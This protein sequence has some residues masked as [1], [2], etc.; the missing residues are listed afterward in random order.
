ML[1][2]DGEVLRLATAIMST[3]LIPRK[4]ETD[5]AHIAV[6]ARHSMDFLI[7]WNCGHIANAEILGRINFVVAETGYF[8][9]IICT[10]DE[11]FGGDENE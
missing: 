9:P 6:A 8:L 11:L 4:A 7:T 2:V 1:E 3:G 5:A 10:P